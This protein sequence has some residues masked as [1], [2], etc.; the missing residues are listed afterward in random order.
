MRQIILLAMLVIVSSCT[1]I[2]DGFGNAT[3]ANASG[4][5]VSLKQA[6]AE[7]S[8]PDG[9]VR[10]ASGACVPDD[11]K[12]GSKT[13][14]SPPPLPPMQEKN[15]K[16]EQQNNQKQTVPD[17]PDDESEDTQDELPMPASLFPGLDPAVPDDYS[18]SDFPLPFLTDEGRDYVF[19][20]SSGSAGAG[21]QINLGGSLDSMKATR[22]FE[23]ELVS[24]WDL[25]KGNN[26]VIIGNAC[27]NRLAKEILGNPVPCDDG[28]VAGKGYVRIVL[29][30]GEHYALLIMGKTN[31][32]IVGACKA[33]GDVELTGVDDSFSIE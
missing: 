22:Y 2:Q 27:N 21:C 29:Y 20:W 9:M 10:D 25:I 8:C 14:I 31:S 12:E 17:V 15:D 11:A 33:L 26:L 3:I 30:D 23:E 7:D 5:N 18:L 6:Q 16:Q 24:K 19:I 4:D 28:L 32:D 1:D 13:I